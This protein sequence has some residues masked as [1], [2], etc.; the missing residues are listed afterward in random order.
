MG[1]KLWRD[2]VYAHSESRPTEMIPSIH[3][4]ISFYGNDFTVVN[5]Y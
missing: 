2:S 1:D 3:N 5:Q 4:S